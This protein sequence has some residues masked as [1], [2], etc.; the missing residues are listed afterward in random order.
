MAEKRVSLTD[1]GLDKFSQ[2]LGNELAQVTNLAPQIPDKAY[3]FHGSYAD[4]ELTQAE[5]KKAADLL[6]R[7]ELGETDKSPVVIVF[8]FAKEQYGVIDLD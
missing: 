1:R 3:I 4:P 6:V 2:F 5:V 7:M 8:E